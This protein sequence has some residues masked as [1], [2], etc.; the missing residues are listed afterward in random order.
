MRSE[1]CFW[2]ARSTGRRSTPA[3]SRPPM[4][5]LGFD[6]PSTETASR[7]LHT[8]VRGHR[9]DGWPVAVRPRSGRCDI[10][11]WRAVRSRPVT[12]CLRSLGWL[13]GGGS[14]SGRQA[15]GEVLA[16]RFELGGSDV[17][18]GRDRPPGRFGGTWPGQ[19]HLRF[20]PCEHQGRI[21]P[22]SFRISG[23]MP[24]TRF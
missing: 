10:G 1:V 20:R 14:R 8:P 13:G 18:E 16:I 21:N 15:A 9:L 24:F 4:A 17:S 3:E 2:V 12:A 6:A 23:T 11:R 19:G 7:Q 22:G 5:R